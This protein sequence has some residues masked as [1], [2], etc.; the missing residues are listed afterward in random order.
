MGKRNL[1]KQGKILSLDNSEKY[2]VID[3]VENDEKHYLL[4]SSLNNIKDVKICL[5]NQNYIEE[6]IDEKTKLQLLR[7]FSKKN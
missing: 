1:K 6:V 7:K 3:E 5:I 2:L 4:L